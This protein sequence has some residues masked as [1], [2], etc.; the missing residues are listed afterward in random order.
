[1]RNIAAD[2]AAPTTGTGT[3]PWCRQ[4]AASTCDRLALYGALA[5]NARPCSAR[6][7]GLSRSADRPAMSS[8]SLQF[9]LATLRSLLHC[10]I[11][12]VI[13][14]G[15]F[16]LMIFTD[17]YF[18]A[19][20]GPG[21][22]AAALGGGVAFFFSFALFNG[23]L[24]YA[25][26][27]VAQYLGAGE[28]HKCSKV[29]SQGLLLA[30]ACIPLLVPIAWMMGGI[31]SAMGHS[32]DQADLERRY[33][34]ILMYSSFFMLVK[35]TLAAYFA[36]IGR[37]RV[38]MICDLLGIA[39][40][41]PLSYLLIFGNAAM[42]PLGIAGAA[43]GT[44]LSSLFTLGVFLLYY[45]GRENRS[46]FVVAASYL[47]DRAIVRRY[48]RLGF[49]AGLEMFLNIAAFNL[50]LLLFQSHGIA[51]A[52]AATIVFNWDILSF[53]PLLGLNIAVMSLVGRAVGAGDLSRIS[54]ITSA[55]YVLGL[56]YSLLLATLYMLFREG[57]VELFI[58][59]ETEAD[60][61]RELAR[62]MMLGLS[63]YVL[64]EGVLQV[65]AG[66]LRG[67]GDTHWCMWASV[68]LHWAM[69]VS[70]YLIIRV[71]Q[72]GPKVSWLGFAFMIFMI[73]VVFLWRLQSNRWRTAERLQAVMAE[74]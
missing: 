55:G 3:P 59:H 11:P 27:L 67:A 18:L 17:R 10:S 28:L 44:V 69:L 9:N 13:S 52:A 33:Y 54:A 72:L 48:L 4:G 61:I 32:A 38:V 43:W 42:A 5:Y 29:V 24:S 62:F 66:V 58:F 25:N 60:A 22:M 39:V 36:G 20:L 34:S 30:T 49:P 1:M 63:C 45:F 8:A 51:A 21:H 50:F 47:Y 64:C 41:I 6:L 53:V 74:S 57:L 71:F 19:Q 26:A 56:G 37:T 7:Q 35:A 73:V 16:A 14:Q 65:A 40:N 12:M 68:A 15:S 2:A 23:I 31:F 46:R 70:Q